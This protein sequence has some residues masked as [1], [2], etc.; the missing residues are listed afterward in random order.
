MKQ[1]KIIL[2]DIDH[3]LFDTEKFR[4]FAFEKIAI[5]L[6]QNYDK[7]FISLTKEA[8]GIAIQALGYFDPEFFMTTLLELIQ[9][10]R[11]LDYIKSNFWENENFEK[12]IYSEVVS[13]LGKIKSID[14]VSIGILSTGETKLQR[15]KVEILKESLSEEHVHIFVN[16]LM[17]LHNVLN[18]YKKHEV[19]VV[20]NLLAVLELAKKINSDV[21]T[22]F[23]KRLESQKSKLKTSFIPD[24]EIKTLDELVP[25]IES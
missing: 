10:N 3:T 14:N 13:A 12:A 8:E 4:Q 25:L 22:V 15:K 23:I 20:D 19:F 21:R 2:F 6:K 11:N 7:K 24:L 17:Q 16:K 18:K 9:S 5:K 1:K